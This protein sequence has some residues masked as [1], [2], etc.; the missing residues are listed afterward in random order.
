MKEP[1]VTVNGVY[2]NENLFLQLNW[3]DPLWQN[4]DM[5]KALAYAIPYDDIINTAYYGQAHQWKGLI[6]S[7]YPYY[8]EKDMY[9]HDP[10]KA[11]EYLAKAGFPNGEGLEAY[12]ESLELTYVVERSTFLESVAV[13]MQTALREVGI[14]ITLNPIPNVQ[15]GDRMIVKKDLPMGFNDGEKAIGP[16]AAYQVMLYFVTPPAGINN[17]ANYSNPTVDELFYKA[18]G[19]VDPVKRDEYLDEIQTTLM[20]ELAWVPIVERKTLV[21]MQNNVCCNYWYPDN[22]LRWKYLDYTD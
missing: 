13:L 8:H 12:P 22:S 1:S 7:S 4:I 6:H 10:D 19:E 14:P 18:R 5:R 2:G 16:D 17:M 11:K 21:A 3:Q 9:S 20:E 15:Y